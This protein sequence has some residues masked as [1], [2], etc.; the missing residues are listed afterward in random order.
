M[1]TQKDTPP[2]TVIWVLDMA[3]GDVWLNG[4]WGVDA[5]IGHQT[6]AHEDV[7]VVL[8]P[9]MFCA[10]VDCL[11]ASGSLKSRTMTPAR[12]ISCWGTQAEAS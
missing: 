6:R 12:A 3:Q 8:E 7:D 9:D 10:L 4:G 1:A 11:R 5:L 2:E